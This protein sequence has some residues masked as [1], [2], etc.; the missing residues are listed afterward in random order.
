MDNARDFVASEGY[1]FKGREYV[2]LAHVLDAA[3]DSNLLS[4]AE[5]GRLF[6]KVD[7]ADM[8]CATWPDYFRLKFFIADHYRGSV[9]DMSTDKDADARRRG[10][11]LDGT[12]A[13]LRQPPLG[14]IIGK[15][16]EAEPNTSIEFSTEVDA[17]AFYA[18]MPAECL[19]PSH[20]NGRR[21]PRF[22]LYEAQPKDRRDVVSVAA[23]ERMASRLNPLRLFDR[24]D[25]EHCDAYGGA[26]IV[27]D[28]GEVIQGNGRAAA[29]RIAFADYPAS[30]SLYT[31]R[32]RKWWRDNADRLNAT[33]GD[34]PDGHV[35]VRVLYDKDSPDEFPDSAA[36][37]L[38]Q[39][40]DTSVTTGGDTVFDARNV[41]R[42][43]Q[44]DHKLGF[45]VGVIMKN[46]NEEEDGDMSLMEC[47]DAN[48]D[49][50]V[51]WLGRHKYITPAEAEA[52]KANGDAGK[53]QFKKVFERILFAGATDNIETMS[54][55]LPRKAQAALFAVAYRDLDMPDGK[56][57]I[58]HLQRSIQA[59][60]EVSAVKLFK[61][62]RTL[63]EALSDLAN[64]ARQGYMDAG[65]Q[66]LYHGDEFSDFEL[67]LVAMYKAM[68]A[69]EIRRTLNDIYDRMEGTSA[70]DLFSP[71]SDAPAT[72]ADAVKSVTGAALGEV[73][74]LTPESRDPS[75][76][77][78][79]HAKL[80]EE[81][82][83]LLN[84]RFAKRERNAVRLT[85]LERVESL[86][87][88]FTPHTLSLIGDYT[89]KDLATILSALG[90]YAAFKDELPK[91]L[92]PFTR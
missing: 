56:K 51:A 22:F 58:P 28:R 88:K 16:V 55:S 3:I 12:E 7:A 61:G 21:N 36:I 42:M 15:Y 71:G 82:G 63:D 85:K 72:L 53:L 29:L 84:G 9:P 87:D 90:H 70:G 27:N 18:L 39:Y 10:F 41:L 68:T 44:G 57:L 4:P 1:S 59:Y 30:A 11:K 86:A 92:S 26:P 64:W 5:L 76:D 49:A 17:P 37:V 81:I 52:C 32:L 75:D 38:G 8:S 43:M 31:A 2:R 6:D 13:Y 62:R 23:A 73:D 24:G 89:N 46:D 80:L 45:F 74:S 33:T 69:T 34:V 77:P 83:R 50:A 20:V 48:Y 65:G 67:Y 60:Y 54:K 47:I 79:E 19:Q 91:L 14:A 25:F 78:E 40:T 66:I 35:L